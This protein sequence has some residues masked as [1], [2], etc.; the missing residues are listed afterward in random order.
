[1]LFRSMADPRQ[2]QLA[3]EGMR[4]RQE[5]I[6]AR[7]ATPQTGEASMFPGVEPGAAPAGTQ[8]PRGGIEFAPGRSRRFP[9]EGTPE[10]QMMVER[11]RRGPGG[12]R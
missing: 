1:M 5:G 6:R 7:E 3:R 2:R 4:M 10:Y 11:M 8:V 12:Q 9:E